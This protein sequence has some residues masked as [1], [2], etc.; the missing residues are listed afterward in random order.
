MKLGQILNEVKLIRNKDIPWFSLKKG[1][2]IK[3]DNNNGFSYIGIIDDIKIIDNW[4]AN[5][6]TDGGIESL[7]EPI[8]TNSFGNWKSF[9]VIIIIDESTYKS[10]YTKYNPSNKIQKLLFINPLSDP[11]EPRLPPDNAKNIQLNNLKLWSYIT[12]IK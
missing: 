2:T 1:D 6:N 3:Y 5:F 9:W 10:K 11:D 12:V 7:N 8:L 4:T